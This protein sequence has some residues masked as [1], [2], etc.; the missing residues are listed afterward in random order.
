MAGKYFCYVGLISEKKGIVYEVDEEVFKHAMELKN[1]GDE[2][3]AARL[4]EKYGRV[5]LMNV[6]G[7]FEGV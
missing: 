3:G 1:S 4:V 2:D 7:F 6:Y 5:V